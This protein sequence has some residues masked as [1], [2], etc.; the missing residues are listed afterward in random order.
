MAG[1][2]APR[3][4]EDGVPSHKNSNHELLRI[5]AMVDVKSKFR[6]ERKKKLITN[7]A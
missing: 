4:K 2:E 1:T 5:S 6:K 3:G 7:E